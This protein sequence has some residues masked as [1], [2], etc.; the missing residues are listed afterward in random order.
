MTEV[1][2]VWLSGTKK[3]KNVTP[4]ILY[5]YALKGFKF[6]DFYVVVI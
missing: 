1:Y 6:L 2:T 4:A 3:N 5:N